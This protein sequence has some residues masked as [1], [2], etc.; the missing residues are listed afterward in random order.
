MLC[1]SLLIIFFFFHKS[2]LQTEFI[3][4]VNEKESGESS[5]SR[6]KQEDEASFR[7]AGRN[8]FGQT[9]GWISRGM[10]GSMIVPGRVGR[11][12]RNRNAKGRTKRLKNRKE[13][14]K[15]KALPLDWVEYL[16]SHH[17][18]KERME[19]FVM[20]PNNFFLP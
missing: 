16:E 18:G 13:E 4:I 15:I 20:K 14:N 9:P 7:D 5:N 19:T 17:R 2:L 11:G 8:K 6:N 10:S 3:E 12:R 1:E